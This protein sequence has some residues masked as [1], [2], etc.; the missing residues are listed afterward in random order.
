MINNIQ[1]FL[2]NTNTMTTAVTIAASGYILNLFKVIPLRILSM[3]KERCTRTVHVT[4]DR[5][6]VFTVMESEIY[7]SY[8]D[9]FDKHISAEPGQVKGI[10]TNHFSISPGVYTKIDWKNLSIVSVLKFETNSPNYGRGEDNKSEAGSVIYKLS[11]SVFGFRSDNI[12]SKFKSII[13]DYMKGLLYDHDK[14]IKSISSVNLW[15]DRVSYT[16]KKKS[17][18]I[19]NEKVLKIIDNHINTFM[20]NESVYDKTGD[21]FKTGI[22]LYGKP[23][24]G[25]SCLAKYIAG[26]LNA[27]VYVLSKEDGR[28]YIP[29]LTTPDNRFKVILMEEIDKMCVSKFAKFGES[30]EKVHTLDNVISALLQLLD[31]FD[32]PGRTIFIATSNDISNLPDALLRDGRFDLKLEMNGIELSDAQAMCIGFGF[33]P[34]SILPNLATDDGLYNPSELRNILLNSIYSSDME[35]DE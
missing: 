33:D 22:L 8:R 5:Y 12:I 1:E 25:K 31:G 14:Y 24:T 11:V 34:D 6:D 30:E 4:S 26:K 16:R 18:N 32:S 3:I 7:N 35:A 21:A 29:R 28:A 13:N 15:S 2:N 17:H 23:G 10:V 9:L 19:Y 27:E 20:S